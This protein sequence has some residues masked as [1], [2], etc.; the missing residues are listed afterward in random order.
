M[1]RYSCGLV[2]C[3]IALGLHCTSALAASKGFAGVVRAPDGSTVACG[4]VGEE[5]S[6]DS[7]IELERVRLA[8]ISAPLL[9]D[10][11]LDLTIREL[12]RIRDGRT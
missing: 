9:A 6:V 2:A 7:V 3:L 8:R 12:K 10:E 1:Q 5:A 4:P 11:N